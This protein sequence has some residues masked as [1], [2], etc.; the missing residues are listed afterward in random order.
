M[1]MVFTDTDRLLLRQAQYA[2]RGKAGY[3][4]VTVLLMLDHGRPA[5]AIAQDLG[6]DEST[7]HRYAQACQRQ[8]LAALLA[9]EAPGYVGR[10]NS[11]QVAELRVEIGRALYTD[12]RQLV[13]WVATTCG[14]RY[15]VS[16]LT[17]LL[18]RHGFSYKLTTAVPCQADAAVQTAFVADTLAPLL[19]AAE[20][21]EAAV[22]FADAAHPTHNTR[23]TYVWT[24]TG[25]E[26][27]LLTVSGRERVN[28]NA[29]LNAVKPTQVHLDE[30]GCVN[31]QSTQRLYE[32]LLAAHPTGPV[33]VVCDNARYYKNK[34]LSTWLT[35][36]RL[37]QVFLPT[38]SPNLN[39][40]ER[41]WKFLRQKI[42]DTQFY[43][44]KGAFKTAVLSFFNRLDEF[45]PALASL[46]NL[47]FHIMDS[48]ITS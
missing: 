46:M 5:A 34:D 35:G 21:G 37:V 12:C 33:Y 10:L 30:T 39:L 26:R 2:C 20:A 24:E 11:S 7:V 43:R 15:S 29:A 9:K 27:P 40:I 6:L 38:Y 28:L 16:G 19:A 22:Y 17:D 36:T 1:Q 32:K 45:G 47:R 18:H 31:A 23:S 48:Q 8:G 41:L 44:T 4:P 42:I 3:V 14:V 13:D 25:K